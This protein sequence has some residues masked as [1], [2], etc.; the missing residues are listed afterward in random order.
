MNPKRKTSGTVVAGFGTADI[1][2]WEGVHLAGAAMGQ[3][4]PAKFVRH[5]LY[6]KACVFKGEK[7]LCIIGLDV[8]IIIE[9]YA[10]Y[11]KDKIVESFDIDRDAIM[12]FAIQSHSAPSVGA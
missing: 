8:T 6:A 7:T 4:R 3:Y 11:I 12:V 10:N 5:K 1:T 2:P 9:K